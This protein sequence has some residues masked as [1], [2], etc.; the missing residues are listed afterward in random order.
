MINID[1]VTPFL[2]DDPPGYLIDF[3]HLHEHKS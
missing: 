1:R 3:Y 2:F